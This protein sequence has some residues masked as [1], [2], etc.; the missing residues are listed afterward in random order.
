VFFGIRGLRRTR[1]GSRGGRWA[2]VLAIVAG[3]LGTLAFVGLVLGVGWLHDNVRAVDRAEA[4]MCVDVDDSDGV[5]FDVRSCSEKHQAEIVA[6]GDI[7][8]I[9]EALT[10]N[11]S[12]SEF[13]YG[14]A[15]E[16]YQRA[17][18]T[19]RYLVTLV[20]GNTVPANPGPGDAYACY[21]TR[22][23]GSLLDEPIPSTKANA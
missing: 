23:D 22:A 12:A 5:S 18:R 4:G 1:D 14:L 20:V 6:A 19:G 16:H 8:D 13:C 9:E 11:A 10:L 15:D 21:F 2:A 17:A 3:A 7:G